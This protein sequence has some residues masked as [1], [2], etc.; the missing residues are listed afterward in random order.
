MCDKV[1][2]WFSTGG[3]D[4]K[5]LSQTTGKH[6]AKCNE[7]KEL[8]IAFTGMVMGKYKTRNFAFIHENLAFLKKKK[9]TLLL[10]KKKPKVPLRKTVLLAKSLD[11]PKKLC[12]CSQGT[13]TSRSLTK[14]LHYETL[15][16]LTN[17]TKLLQ[18]TASTL[19]YN[20]F[21]TTVSC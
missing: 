6:N 7:K 4:P 8:T 12:I 10:I 1:K 15:H 20:F 2:K 9:K 18:A 5:I 19:K 14:V 17:N 3:C 13:E 11:S 16:S 21:P